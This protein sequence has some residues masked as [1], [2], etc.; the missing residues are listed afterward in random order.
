MILAV[1]IAQEF[2]IVGV[3]GFFMETHPNPEEAL[4]DKTT[5]YP[6]DSLELLLFELKAI[7]SAS[8]ALD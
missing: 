7:A 3:D 4:C 1:L 6:L 8:K 2:A 5:M